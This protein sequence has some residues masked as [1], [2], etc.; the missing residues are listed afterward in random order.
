MGYRQLWCFFDGW[1]GG[2]RRYQRR[3]ISGRY[4]R[5]SPLYQLFRICDE[6]NEHGRSNRWRKWPWKD[7]SIF[8]NGVMN[9][10]IPS[11]QTL[12]FRVMTL[13]ESS[14]IFRGKRSTVIVFLVSKIDEREDGTSILFPS[15]SQ[16]NLEL[17]WLE[18]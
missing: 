11:S 14:L 4:A 18:K 15:N 6:C 9:P 2:T 3:K 13:L 17:L 7:R 16:I 10:R 8:T 12:C 1:H 5:T